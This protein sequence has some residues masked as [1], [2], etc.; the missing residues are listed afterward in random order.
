MQNVVD[1]AFGEMAYKIENFAKI[2]IKQFGLSQLSA[3]RAASTYMAMAKGM[4]IAADDASDMAISLTGLTGDLASFYNVSHDVAQTAL[5]SIFTGETESLKKFGIVM[6]EVNLQQ[7]AFEKGIK[8]SI[9]TMTQQEKTML[10]Y[11]YVMSQTA[12]AQGDFAKTQDSFANKTRVIAQRFQEMQIVIGQTLIILI[13]A[14][15]PAIET[16]VK[17]L[18]IAA[19]YI[20]AFVNGMR[21]VSSEAS[22]TVDVTKKLG[23]Q[24]N[25]TAN[26]VNTAADAIENLGESTKETNKQLAQFDDLMILQSASANDMDIDS[27]IGDAFDFS[28]FEIPDLSELEAFEDFLGSDTIQAISDFQD[29]VVENKDAIKTALEV[30]GAAALGVAIGNVILKIG[31][32]LG[33]FKRKDQALD[34]QRGK[35]NAE[36]LAMLAVA[37]AM[38]PVAVLAKKVAEGLETMSSRVG[39]LI[40]SLVTSSVLSS[41]FGTA[42]ETVK[43]KLE[44][45]PE[46]VTEFADG[47][48]NVASGALETVV[49]LPLVAPI[50]TTVKN[51]V[52][53]LNPVISTLKTNFDNIKSPFST[54]VEIAKQVYQPFK[55]FYGVLKKIPGLVTSFKDE[56]KKLL[57]SYDLFNELSV[58]LSPNLDKVKESISNIPAEISKLWG[59]IKDLLPDFSTLN[60]LADSLYKGFDKIKESAKNLIEPLSNLWEKIKN[61]I[62]DYTTVKDISEKLKPLW[63]G[64]KDILSQIA[65]PLQTF[66]DKISALKPDFGKVAEI[67]SELFPDLD[68]LKESIKNLFSPIETFIE[69]V[70][71]LYQPIVDFASALGDVKSA[72]ANISSA[73]SGLLSVI[74]EFIVISSEGIYNWAVNIIT[75]IGKTASSISKSFYGA[76]SN[77]IT[78]VSTFVSATS[79]G[80]VDFVTNIV[81]NLSVGF[82]SL[83][84]HL[85]G[86]IMNIWNNFVNLMGAIGEGVKNVFKWV[87]TPEGTKTVLTAGALTAASLL[88]FG[89]T[90]LS[91]VPGDEAAAIPLLSKAVVALKTL[92]AS[93]GTAV[94]GGGMLAATAM[95][96]GGIVPTATYALIGEQGREAVLPL[97]NHTSWMDMLADRIIS[98]QGE[99]NNGN[100]TVVLEL[101]GREFGRAVVEQGN[102]E[103]RRI[104]T[105][106]VIK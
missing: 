81:N 103:T 102:K 85:K 79:Q 8:K 65:A 56:L 1:T 64:I 44:N 23:T 17:Y 60:N 30:A 29:W 13:D 83:A 105:R 19:L 3:K 51:A 94:T 22:K 11:A 95:A 61:L 63:D 62:P 92:G 57:P 2:S 58:K 88:A 21:G 76:L 66:I 16:L 100:T 90:L 49:T 46:T 96:K 20:A 37:V 26:S 75:N 84:D 39:E 80:I 42:V 33:W 48:K 25:K 59:K 104:G 91:P 99:T 41:A 35:L 10:R 72:I 52:K 101:D 98:R 4:G 68:S 36:S 27:G 71:K 69:W 18:T 54:F 40:P 7:F 87:Q 86:V 24:S 34:T 28:N 78:N 43:T 67:A 14:L 70:G 32:L 47:L 12:M 50:V 15:L 77:I 106:L 45:V 89:A 31:E 53:K 93:I 38:A 74:S 9:S 82:K 6:T 55:D 73:F 5:N 97:D